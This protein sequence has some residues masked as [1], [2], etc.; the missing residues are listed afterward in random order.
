MALLCM[1]SRA[2]QRLGTAINVPFTGAASSREPVK[3]TITFCAACG[4]T[5]QAER[6][7]AELVTGGHAT[8]LDG[9]GRA[10]AFEVEATSG[11]RTLRLWSK[12]ETGEP[13]SPE[14]HRALA[15]L[16]KRELRAF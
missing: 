9:S 7:S 3:V 14:A 11:K 15:D 4:Y 10:G 1:L 13:S 8:L 2:G 16:L 5:K 12:L 6:L